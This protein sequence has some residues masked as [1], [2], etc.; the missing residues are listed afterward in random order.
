MKSILQEN[1]E[2][3]PICYKRIMEGTGSW[4]HIY[5]GKNKRKSEEDGMKIFIHTFPCHEDVQTNAMKLVKLQAWYQPRWCEYYNKTTEDFIKRFG[6][7][8]IVRYEQLRR[9]YGQKAVRKTHSRIN[10]IKEKET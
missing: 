8:Y 9:E 3:C 5:A 6:Q 10:E 7:D 2:Y 1:T 4:H